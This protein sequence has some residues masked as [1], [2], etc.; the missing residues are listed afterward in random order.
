MCGSGSTAA[1][2]RVRA[3][4]CGGIRSSELRDAATPL[5]STSPECPFSRKS[6]N[7]QLLI[8]D[9]STVSALRRQTC[10]TEVGELAALD[11]KLGSADRV[12]GRQCCEVARDSGV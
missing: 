4:V 11:I 12:Q 9:S 7:R 6:A 8:G 3:G 5:P 2:W 10:L 1:D